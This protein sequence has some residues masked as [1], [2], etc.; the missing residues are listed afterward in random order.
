[1]LSICMNIFERTIHTL[2]YDYV[3]VVGLLCSQQSGFTKNHPTMTTFI[4]VDV[5]DH[6]YDK[7][8]SLLTEI[9]FLDL[10]K[11]F[12]TVYP[13]VLLCK[14]AWIGVKNT[15]LAW[16]TNYMTGCQQWVNHRVVIYLWDHE[17]ILWVS[18]GEYTEATPFYIFMNDLPQ[19]IKHSSIDLYADETM[20]VYAAKTVSNIKVI[21]K[22]DLTLLYNWLKQNRLH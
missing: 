7:D 22:L 15:E 6:K 9:I 12:D 20:L 1:M 11:A 8:K 17:H 19:C 2:L 4:I 10:K 21:F 13:E 16:F 18:T 5:T 14:L 3:I